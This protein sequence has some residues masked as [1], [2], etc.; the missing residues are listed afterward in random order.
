V[1]QLSSHFFANPTF[2]F[3]LGIYHGHDWLFL[4]RVQGYCQIKNI[5]MK[6]YFGFVQGA[7][8][9]ER[10]RYLI[11]G[12]AYTRQSRTISGSSLFLHPKAPIL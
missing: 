11:S 3:L 8:A 7:R 6:I 5:D 9:H 4:L 12:G 2:Y 1:S 10:K